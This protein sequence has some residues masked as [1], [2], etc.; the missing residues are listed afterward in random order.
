MSPQST[1]AAS[2][3]WSGPNERQPKR[4][5]G[6]VRGTSADAVAG[7]AGELL[8]LAALLAA[9]GRQLAPRRFQYPVMDT[10]THELQRFGF[11]HYGK[12]PLDLVFAE[13][14]GGLRFTR[15]QPGPQAV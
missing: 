11:G 3:L 1:R 13:V 4:K 7:L 10:V 15:H 12:F 14:P 6:A 2:I 5:L 8:L 9:A